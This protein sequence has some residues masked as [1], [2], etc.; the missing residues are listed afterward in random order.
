MSWQTYL[1]IGGLDDNMVGL[2]DAISA[3]LLL[4]LL[5]HPLS[6]PLSLSLSSLPSILPLQFAPQASAHPYITNMLSASI[7]VS[8]IAIALQFFYALLRLKMTDM[9]KLR[10]M[11]KE[12]NDWRREYMD[13]IRKQDKDR[14]EKLRDKQEYINRLNMEVMQMNFRPMMVFMIPML[15]IWWAILPQVFGH[16]VAISPISLNIVGD[17]L[18]ITCTKG[19]IVKDVNSITEEISKHAEAIQNP[20]IR[21]QVTS[22]AKEARELVDAGQYVTARDRILTAYS[23]L[24]ANLENKVQERV[25]SC[26][27]E[28]EVLLWAWYAI[29]SIAFSGIVMKITRTE[30]SIN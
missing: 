7:L 28:N 12:V 2:I 17:L 4:P 11:M 3:Y 22:L 18:P 5:L 23:I 29:A 15:I 25:P 1:L 13:A 21:D 16:T 10:R 9:Q 30:M 26:I 24:N 6:S 14:I 27:A 20:V 8:I 19:M